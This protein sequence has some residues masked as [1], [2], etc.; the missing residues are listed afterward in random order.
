MTI[1]IIRSYLPG[2]GAMATT[3]HGA[4][5]VDITDLSDDYQ[6]DPF[7]ALEGTSGLVE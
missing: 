1:A 5:L 2:R 7:Q 6:D 3:P 4:G